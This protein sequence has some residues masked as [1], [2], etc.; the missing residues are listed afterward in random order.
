MNPTGAD[1]LATLV[2]RYRRELEADDTDDSDSA[3]AK[4]A[5]HRTWRQ[6]ARTPMLTKADALAALDLFEE[7]FKITANLEEPFRSL[8]K[9]RRCT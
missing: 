8:I 3:L 1:T 7:E 5:W 6:I 2:T 4:C 9:S